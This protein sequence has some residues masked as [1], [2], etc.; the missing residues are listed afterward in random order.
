LD[1][2][3]SLSADGAWILFTSERAGSADIYRVRSDGSQLERLTDDPAF[4]D[5]A[6]LSPDGRSIAFV[7]SRK[8]GRAHV[9]IMDVATRGVRQLTAGSGGDFRPA[10]SPDGKSIAFSSDRG[11]HPGTLPGRW[12]L[13][14]SAGVYVVHADGTGLKRITSA[15]GFAGSPRWSPDGKRVVFYETTELGTWYA[16]MGDVSK[17]TT[18]IVSVD[19]DSGR[20]VQYTDGDGIRLWP[21]ML[22]DGRVV[23][24]NRRSANEI[25]IETQGPAGS[26]SL[27]IG[28]GMRNP[29]WIADGTRL[30]FQ[31]VTLQDQPDPLHASFTAQPDF[32]IATIV[33]AF[34][35]FSPTGDR[36]LACDTPPGVDGPNLGILIMRPD[37]TDAR[38]LF[39][40]KGADAIAPSWSPRGDRIAFSKGAYFRAP[41]HPSAQVAIMNAD[42]SAVRMITND[43]ANN[44]FPSWS[45]D[46]TRIVFKKDQHLVIASI[47]DETV[48][49][50]TEPGAQFDNF[51]QWS[52]AGDRIAFTSNR[53]G[54]FE[55]YTIA[56]DGTDLR[57]LTAAAGNNAHAI[58]S[59]DGAWLLFSSGR[60]GFKDERPLLDHIPQPY[61]ELFVMR[62][63]G[64]D[65]R[66]LTDNQWEDATPAW[67][68]ERPTPNR[69]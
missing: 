37:G 13:L 23:F 33:G 14:Q 41:G 64:A 67:V 21:Q 1:Y 8:D 17:G 3:P 9:W 63:D 24:L 27:P 53:S 66:Q 31:K 61:G 10:W 68:P 48:T 12:E 20:R 35:V 54:D 28:D 39:W 49:N 26:T 52:P 45:A 56:P 19:V 43:G 69:R 22:N 36:L 2:S 44:G 40:E 60:M 30:V 29:F 11:S 15:G 16:A 47:A 57:R 42:G 6:T 32:K 62:S 50:L 18:Q 34:P 55:I 46:G 5:Q 51:P 7:S 4:D 58:W 38:P 59:P 65:V 25:A